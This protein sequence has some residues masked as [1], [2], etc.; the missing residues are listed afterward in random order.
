LRLGKEYQFPLSLKDEAKPYGVTPHAVLLPMGEGTPSQPLRA[1]S[2]S[3]GE[4]VRVRGNVR[5]IA[6][7][8]G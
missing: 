2:L 4:R 7:A 5:R 8:W 6:D 1:N 3:H